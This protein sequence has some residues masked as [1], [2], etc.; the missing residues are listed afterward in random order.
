MS[1]EVREMTWDDYRLALP[2]DTFEIALAT[3]SRVSQALIDRR[4][5]VERVLRRHW[6]G[7]LR[8]GGYQ[9]ICG[10]METH[11]PADFYV[12][13]P[14]DPETLSLAN[15]Y[16]DLRDEWIA[17]YRIWRFVVPSLD[18]V[19]D[20]GIAINMMLE[21]QPPSGPMPKL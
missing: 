3:F 21:R 1:G 11:K 18:D 5:P 2:P 17:K 15:P 13:L 7:F 16:P 10:T 14:A 8:Q 6:W 20:V 4:T 9:T 12:K 19:P